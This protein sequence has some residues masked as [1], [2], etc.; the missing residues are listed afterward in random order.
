MILHKLLE[1][2]ITRR[3]SML[4]IEPVADDVEFAV[5]HGESIQESVLRSRE[6]RLGGEGWKAT[7]RLSSK[8]N[9]VLS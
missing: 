3:N 5:F 2:L 8:F 7:R 6:T 1:L 4:K 9:C